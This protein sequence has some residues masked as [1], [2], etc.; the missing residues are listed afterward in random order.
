MQKNNSDLCFACKGTGEVKVIKTITKIGSIHLGKEIKEKCFFCNN[1][2]QKLN[3][4]TNTHE[5]TLH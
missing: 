1:H 5:R 4:E 2:E 3:Q